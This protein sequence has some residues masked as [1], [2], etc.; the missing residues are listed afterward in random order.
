MTV[1]S[2]GWDATVTPSDDVI[3]VVTLTKE[4]AKRTSRFDTGKLRFL[5]QD[6]LPEFLHRDLLLVAQLATAKGRRPSAERPYLRNSPEHMEALAAFDDGLLYALMRTEGPQRCL[7]EEKIVDA[8]AEASCWPVGIRGTLWESAKVPAR[9]DEAMASLLNNEPSFL[10]L[11]WARGLG[12]PKTLDTLVEMFPTHEG[13]PRAAI[14]VMS[15]IGG[16]VAIRALLKLCSVH[17]GATHARAALTGIEHN[18]NVGSREGASGGVANAEPSDYALWEK[19]N[20]V[21]TYPIPE[22]GTL[23]EFQYEWQNDVFVPQRIR[24]VF[25]TLL[26]ASRDRLQ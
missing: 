24:E 15:D 20:H 8:V 11:H 12:G 9:L 2:N 14:Y 22:M 19:F 6:G 10:A 25:D 3:V 23:L 7:L 17:C 4:L 13:M 21:T 5:D 16:P 1:L 26:A 18:A